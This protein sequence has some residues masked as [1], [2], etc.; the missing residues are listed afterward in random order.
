MLERIGRLAEAAAAEVA[1]SRRGFFGRFVGLAGGAALALLTVA[2]PRA[3]ARTIKVGP[4][5]CNCDHPPSYG[6]KTNK[7]YAYQ[8]CVLAC[9]AACGI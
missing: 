7:G 6:C 8:D 3:S 2:T 4:Y 5:N 1:V 9:H